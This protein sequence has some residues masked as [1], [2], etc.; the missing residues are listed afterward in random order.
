MVHY[1]TI[2]A[3][4]ARPALV[5]VNSL[6][7][8]CRIWTDLVAHLGNGYTSVAYDMRGQGLTDAGDAPYSLELLGDDLA[9]LMEHTGAGPAIVCG[10]SLGGL[11][12]QQLHVL[13]PDLVQALVLCDTAARIGDAAFWNAR[14]AA[15]QAGG[16]KAI[17]DG[18]L[19]RWFGASWRAKNDAAFAGYRNMLTRQPADGYVAACG[20]L[21][22]ADLSDHARDID[23]PTLCVVGDSD[24]STP[25]DIVAA[26]ARAIP[27]A[28][29]EIVEDCGHLP[30]IEQP[31]ALAALIQVFAATIGMETASYVGH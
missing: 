3:E 11:V 17:A 28:R 27:G 20:A 10:V 8:D 4:S 2:G 14:I 24:A 31:G 22:R 16:M 21:A 7:T 29:L 15:I 5:F 26:L 18:V 25:P 19:E 13:R 30:C 9:A 6:G 1:Q 23:V 12:A